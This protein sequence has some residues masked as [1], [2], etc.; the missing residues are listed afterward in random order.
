MKVFLIAGEPSGDRLGAALMAG[1]K[2]LSP[3]VSFAGVGGVAMHGEGMVSQFEM[4]E[5][6]VMGISEVLP[7]YFHLKRR[8]REVAAEVLRLRPDVLI[9]IDSPDFCL[10]VAKIVKSEG[11]AEI[12]IVHYVAPSVWAWRPKRAVK[13]ARHVDHVLALL[14]FEPKY[15]HEAGMGCDFV[16]HPVVAEPQATAHQAQAF[17]DIHDVGDG[18]LLLALPGSRKG[19][20]ARGAERFGQ[21][22]GELAKSHPGLKV[23]L[24]MAQ[25]VVDLVRAET[26]KWPVQPILIAPED[27]DAK[28]AAFR[29]ADLALATSGTVSLELAAAG[30]PMVIAYE[31]SWLSRLVIGNLLLID[32]VTLVNLVSETRAVPEFLAEHCQVENIIPALEEVLTHRQSQDYAMDLTMERLGKGGEAPGL[33]AARA[34]LGVV[35]Q[36]RG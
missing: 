5:L 30:T 21:V 16:G 34:V 7:K 4:S 17:R 22:F 19:E 1:L 25:G 2:T 36:G 10:R 11:G 6:S 15:M 13:M 8:I 31:M 14:P 9:T 33:R 3:E 26:A 23:V 29:A 32:T 20:I 35:E 28:R 27:Q 24:P 12:P 18:P